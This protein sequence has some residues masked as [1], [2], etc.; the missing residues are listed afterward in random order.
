M[1]QKVFTVVGYNKMN[2]ENKMQS[3]QLKYSV[4]CSHT[5]MLDLC[6]CSSRTS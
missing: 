3:K 5:Y 2:G 4:T 6:N 1:L